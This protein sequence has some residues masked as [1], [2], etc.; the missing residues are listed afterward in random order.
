MVDAAG[1]ITY[2]TVFFFHAKSRFEDR[3]NIIVRLFGKGTP[4]AGYF[5]GR[6]RKIDF[7]GCFVPLGADGLHPEK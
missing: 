3:E 1:E 6:F 7:Y 2:Q 5:F 4:F